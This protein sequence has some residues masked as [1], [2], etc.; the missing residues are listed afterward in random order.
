MAGKTRRTLAIGP[1]TRHASWFWLGVD[2][3]ELL[4][5]DFDLRVYG[6]EE[7][8]GDCDAALVIKRRL[9]PDVMR[10][11]VERCPRIIYMPVDFYESPDQ[12]HEDGWFLRRCRACILHSSRLLPFISELCS[13]VGYLQHYNKFGLVE[14]TS[15]KEDGDILWIGHYE[16]VPY[17]LEWLEMHNPPHP[18]RILSNINSVRAVNKAAGIARRAG[19]AMLRRD[20]FLNGHVLEEWSPRLQEHRL[21]QAKAAI[22]IKGC[23]HC[24][25][26]HTKPA[27]KG[28][29]Y[30]ASGVPLAINSES[31]TFDYFQRRGFVVA[32]PEDYDRWFSKSYYDET[33][34]EAGRLRE[35]LSLANVYRELKQFIDDIVHEDEQAGLAAGSAASAAS[36]GWNRPACS[37]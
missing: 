23:S 12:I 24:F 17:L 34:S 37:I 22:D 3:L 5:E 27:T 28:Q 20:G 21:Q 13:R 15:Y 32:S 8:P 4:S 26:Q 31:Y 33:V 10:D 11:W 30:V 16:H 19:V 2:F 18:V 29:K 35:E 9:K 36:G 6:V 1:V 7:A 25:G 14:P